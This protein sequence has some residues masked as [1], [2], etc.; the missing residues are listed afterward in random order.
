[1]KISFLDFW[2]DFEFNNNFITHALRQIYQ[3]L[4]IVSPEDSDIII[5]SV[6]GNNHHR[7][8]N[9]KKIIFYTGENIRPTYQSYQKSI[10]FDFDSYDNKNLRIP[11]WYFYIDWFNVKSYGNPN[12]L[13]PVDYLYNSNEFILKEKNKFCCT[14][15]SA[16]HQ[17]RF[18]MINKLNEYKLVDCY[19]KVFQNKISDGEKIKM[20][21]I[22][23]YKFSICF[24]NSI[25]PGY[26]TEKLL[27]AKIA[28]TIPI[29][30]SHDTMYLDFNKNCCIN[31]NN[32]N[33][34]EILNI[35]IEID[36]NDKL[37]KQWFQQPL[38]ENKI[39]I[40]TILNS[41]KNLI[42]N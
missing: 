37:Y 6:F 10:S 25:Y 9:N 33:L 1:M 3:D 28:G 31:T 39:D 15:F 36:N 40:N 30:K 32:M 23:N 41:I 24:E 20:D 2:G 21:I 8:I 34:D 38:F 4:Q 18:Q 11:L 13:L 42:E 26:Y 35:V 7:F 12:Y 5:C 22:S 17:D 27:H 14:I 19:G 16:P 29:Y